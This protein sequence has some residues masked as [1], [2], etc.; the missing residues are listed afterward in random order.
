MGSF[1]EDVAA[2][3]EERGGPSTLG[4]LTGI[5]LNVCLIAVAV[6]LTVKIGLVLFT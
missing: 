1:R 5:T 3:V 6:M 4:R 2:R